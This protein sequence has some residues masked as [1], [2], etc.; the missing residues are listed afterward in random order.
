MRSCSRG[1]ICSG[2]SCSGNKKAPR[3]A[4]LFTA[5]GIVPSVGLFRK[6][7]VFGIFLF[8]VVNAVLGPLGGLH[9]F[10]IQVLAGGICCVCSVPA[11]GFNR[12]VGGSSRSFRGI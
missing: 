8:V 4:G 6:D 9:R 5:G 12:F 10:L 2:G 7:S 3:Q 1:R 11:S